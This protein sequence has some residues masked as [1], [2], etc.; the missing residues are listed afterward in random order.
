MIK[1]VTSKTEWDEFVVNSGGHPL[2][3]WGWGELK[4]K[5]GPWK[6]YRLTVGNHGR[7][8][9]LIRDL[10][11]PFHHMAYIP[12]GPIT[13]EQGSRQQAL[14]EIAKWAK[15][16]GCIELKIEPDWPENTPVP[17]SFRRSKNNIQLG[18]TVI[19]DL[20]KSDEELLANATKKT[21]QYIRKSASSGVTVRE[22]N[23]V[24]DIKKCLEIYRQTA[25]RA[26]FNLH[27]DDYYYSLATLLGK[28]NRIFVAEN[29]GEVVSFLW[30]IATPAVAFE[31]YGGVNEQGMELRANYA[32][33][34]EAIQQM[35]Q[36]RVAQYDMNGLLND[37]VSNFKLG[38]SGNTETN[39]IGTLDKSL[40][41][42][43]GLWETVIPLGKKI[44]HSLHK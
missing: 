24:A 1:E 8:Q 10:P 12:R 2:Q 3:L 41:P 23:N 33:K 22:T 31:L 14:D 6:A 21:R 39:L 4:S 28:N 11:R 42:L 9:V 40:S 5:T 17:K 13:A 26:D 43:Y 38:F 30:L 37:G 44:T 15:K 36:S 16:Q 20:G 19:L 29:G 18:R 35:K 32:L 7:A 27:G 34:W 25:Q